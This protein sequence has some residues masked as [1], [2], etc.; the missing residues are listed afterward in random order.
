MGI[1]LKEVNYSY[2]K[3]SKIYAL[4]NI[5]LDINTKDEFISIVGET[6]SGKSTLA[7]IFNYLKVPTSGTL[8]INDL[9]IKKNKK[10][11]YNKIR[12]HVGL[13]FQF[14]D[15]QLFEETVLKDVSFGPSNFGKTKEEATT[16]A[17]NA[18]NSLDMDESYYNKSPFELSGGEKRLASI[19]GII[20]CD[21]DIIVFDEPTAGLDAYKKNILMNLLEKLN[22]EYHKTI[23]MITHDMNIA[24]KYSKRIILL[25]K[26]NI[27]VD[28]T[29]NN[30]FS[31]NNIKLIED[32]NIDLPD[33]IRIKNYLNK[34]CNL[35]LTGIYKSI[36]D[37]KKELLE[38]E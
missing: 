8:I 27:V 22:K 24:L 10:I 34:K 21:N 20:A 26:G 32:S 23:I 3:K 13:C 14:S 9:L 30:L 6:G 38:N 15:Y 11:P 37:I 7:S 18:L 12:K 19:A 4:N 5:N 28:T 16:L 17:K 1:S 31:D 35:N 29:P 25:S 36:D 33:S 2:N